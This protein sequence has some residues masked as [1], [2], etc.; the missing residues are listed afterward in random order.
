VIQ[1]EGELVM[2][3]YAKFGLSLAAAT[4]VATSLMASAALA[5]DNTQVSVKNNQEKTIKVYV[6]DGKDTTRW[7]TTAQFYVDSGKT[8]SGYC[9]GQGKGR[10]Y[11][12]IFKTRGEKIDAVKW[13]GWVED[14]GICTVPKSASGARWNEV[15]CK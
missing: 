11:V 7:S 8:G 9:A 10:C 4:V 13:G 14:G 6:Y 15:T 5:A 12:R 1:K 3:N 2:K